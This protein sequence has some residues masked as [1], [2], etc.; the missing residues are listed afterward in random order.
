MTARKAPATLKEVAA[1]AGVSISCVSV[2]MNGT[3]SGTRVSDK[4]RDLVIREAARLGYR[5]NAIGRSLQRR[6]T[7]VLG[8]LSTSFGLDAGNAFL[9]DLIGGM[10]VACRDRD[11][12]LLLFTLRDDASVEESLHRLTDGYVD[13][14]IV[15]GSGDH[16]VAASLAD[17]HLPLVSIVDPI[18]GTPFVRADD[19]E[20]GRMLAESLAR[21]GYEQILYR[22]PPYP[23][24]SVDDRLAAFRA[25]SERLGMTVT[26]GA[27]IH[28]DTTAEV[29]ERELNWIERHRGQRAAIVVWED[30]TALA[31]LALLRDHGVSVPE[32]LGLAGY[33]G[34][35]TGPW[36]SPPLTTVKAPWREVAYEAVEM[37]VQL[38]EG[39]STESGRVLPVHVMCRA[40]TQSMPVREPVLA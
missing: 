24:A 28:A 36:P 10:Q 26:L 15:L 5:P 19:V 31:T 25:T 13:G 22:L 18:P 4:T 21:Q 16:P 35:A 27:N 38:I 39:E 34:I 20:G 7:Q 6:R 37:L 33:N 30:H 14:L 17:T 2:V 29:D 12:A 11:L 23:V 8:F 3:R 40:T 9:A 1:A 32:E